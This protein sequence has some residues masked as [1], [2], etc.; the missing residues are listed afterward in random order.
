M[1]EG[2]I[3]TMFRG[4]L[5]STIKPVLAD[6]N[7]VIKITE[8]EFREMALRGIDESFRKNIEIRIK[9]GYIE[10]TVRLL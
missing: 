5:P 2:L 9:E 8:P 7:I 10:V 1:S 6:N 3:N 4:I